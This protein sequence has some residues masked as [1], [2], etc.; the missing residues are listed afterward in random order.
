MEER[1]L[2]IEDLV[3]TECLV[4]SDVLEEMEK[5]YDG[6][7]ASIDP[8]I[9]YARDDGKYLIDN[10]NKR[11]VFLYLEGELLIRG[12]VHEDPDEL[13]GLEALAAKAEDFSGVK[14]IADLAEKVVPRDEY[15]LFMGIL[16]E[17]D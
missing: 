6:N 2:R 4:P 17:H 3:P 8:I 5:H 16:D 9:V 15:D 7:V 12:Y 13:A 10:G 11:S 1:I 14:T